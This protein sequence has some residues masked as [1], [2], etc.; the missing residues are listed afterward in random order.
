MAITRRQKII[1]QVEVEQMAAEGKCLARLEGKII[2]ISGV[3]PG[4]VV[5]LRITKRKKQFLEAVPVYFHQHSHLRVQPFCEHFGECGGCQWQH[6]PYTLQLKTK[7]QQ[8]TDQLQR[9]AKVKLPE[10]SPILPSENTTY[11][12]NKLEFTFSDNRWLTQKEIDSGKEIN[13]NALGFHKPQAFNK[14]LQIHHCHLQPNPS[15]AIR[16]AI[17]QYAKENQISYYNFKSHQGILRN[18]TVRTTST[19]EIMVIIQFGGDAEQAEVQPVIQ[20]LLNYV[21]ENF[22]EINALLYLINPKKNETIYDQELHTFSGT[23]FITERMEHLRFRIGPKSFFQTNS[24]QAHQLYALVRTFADLQGHETVYDL[25]TGT[26]TIANFIARNS[27]KVVGID[28]VPEA[29]KDAK[30]NAKLN[31]IENVS[32]FSGDLKDTLHAEFM[33]QQGKPDVII[34]D[35]PRSGMHE[36]VV[37]SLLL[38]APKKIVYVSCNPATQARDLALLDE[39]YKVVKVQPVDMFPHTHHVENIVLLTHRDL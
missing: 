19:G 1:E 25:Y 15:N 10:I 16:L 23:D 31:G 6:I 3:A 27:G 21:K 4:D 38:A 2:F 39:K 20:G 26:G 13:K 28:Y 33:E 32:F 34:T 12:R 9:I 8:V 14:V 36:G 7:Q 18:L 22:P 37:K 17:D 11:Y 29:I 30:T 24:E 5:D 35:P